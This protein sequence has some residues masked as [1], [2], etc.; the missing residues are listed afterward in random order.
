[1]DIFPTEIWFKIFE[2]CI[3]IGINFDFIAGYPYFE[4]I[5]KTV[6]IKKYPI[7]EPKLINYFLHEKRFGLNNA[8]IGCE[9]LLDYFRKENFH[10]G[11][12]KCYQL[13]LESSGRHYN[14]YLKLEKYQW[15]KNYLGEK[16]RRLKNLER[17][18]HNIFSSDNLCK[19]GKNH[20]LNCK[21]IIKCECGFAIRCG[22][23]IHKSEHFVV[24]PGLQTYPRII[25]SSRKHL[26]EGQFFKEIFSY[27]EFLM[28][29]ILGRYPRE[30]R[31]NYGRE[32]IDFEDKGKHKHVH[33]IYE[34]DDVIEMVRRKWNWKNR[35]QFHSLE[36]QFDDYYFS[37]RK[38]NNFLDHDNFDWI[39][40][41]EFVTNDDIKAIE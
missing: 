35:T 11:L 30:I 25:I 39:K 16:V 37:T 29:N 10:K 3:E 14:L 31:I 23:I 19:R 1:M 2:E 38:E 8:K 15:H 20:F 28:E 40:E 6:K 12:K 4:N 9:I 41:K 34:V 32:Y 13:I 26:T 7:V 33:L 17:I 22:S 18:P 24:H 27:L 36:R 21:D 5:L